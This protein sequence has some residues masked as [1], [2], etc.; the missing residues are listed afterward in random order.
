MANETI[1]MPDAGNTVVDGG[2]TEIQGEGKESLFLLEPALIELRSDDGSRFSIDTARELGSGGEAVVVIATDEDGAEYAAKITP[3]AV[4]TREQKNRRKVL[5]FLQE[6]SAGSSEDFRYQHL[7]PVYAHGTI[8]AVR[9]GGEIPEPFSVAIMPICRCLGD[10]VLE[11]AFVK[12]KVIPAISEAIHFLHENCIVHRDV[13]PSNIFEHRGEIVLGDF[14][15]S[16]VFEEG[17]QARGTVVDRRTPGYTP[18]NHV[19]Q[20]EDDWYSFGYTIW[21]MY[22]GNVHPHQAWIDSNNLYLIEQ[23]GERPVAFVPKDP[24]DKTLGE[25]IYGLTAMVWRDRLGYEGVRSWI[26]SPE[27]FH[28]VDKKAT[29]PRRPYR[30]E[31]EEL[32]D[33]ISIAQAFSQKWEEAKP[34]LYSRTLEEYFKKNGETDLAS[35]LYDIVEGDPSTAK[36]KDLGLAEAIYLVSGEERLMFWKGSDVSLSAL[37]VAFSEADVDRLFAYDDV[38][39]SPFLTWAMSQWDSEES[40]AYRSVFTEASSTAVRLP[41]F[42]RC[43][44][45]FAVAG[46]G[47]SEY[48]GFECTEDL[49]DYALETPKRFYDAAGSDKRVDEL[50]AA[51]VPYFASAGRLNSLVKLRESCSD[52]VIANANKLLTFFDS[53]DGGSVAARR[54]FT[55]FS[56][57]AAWFWMVE[58]VDLYRA[59]SGHD[60]AEAALAALGACAF[61]EDDTVA[62]GAVSGEKARSKAQAAIAF[63]SDSPLF[64]Q[65][66]VFGEHPVIA[67]KEDAL[68]CAEFYGRRVPR[69]FVRNLLTVSGCASDADWEGVELVGRAAASG[70]VDQLDEFISSCSKAFDAAQEAKAHAGSFAK[71]VFRCV[72]CLLAGAA[73]FAALPSMAEGYSGLV[74]QFAETFLGDK[75]VVAE[76]VRPLTIVTTSAMVAFF[77]VDAGYAL[78]A[79]SR[80]GKAATVQSRYE[81]KAKEMKKAAQTF[82]SGEHELARSL[83]TVESNQEI[84]SESVSAEATEAAEQVATLFNRDKDLPYKVAWQVTAFLAALFVF[85]VSAPLIASMVS[86]EDV[87]LMGGVPIL[88]VLWI[89]A[90]CGVAAFLSHRWCNVGTWMLL[91]IVPIVLVT[92]ALVVMFVVQMLVYLIAVIIGGIAVLAVFAG[93]LSS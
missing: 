14:G 81:G 54:F 53:V 45:Q 3:P 75:Q 41:R 23:R 74:Y 60:M 38:L 66:G 91:L 17:E 27:K 67:T 78:F 21:T 70:A 69:G 71:S 47:P 79:S 36:D 39:S 1:I 10:E 51:F 2:L 62:K 31:G 88:F 30:F 92:A 25:L 48:A 8:H 26:E 57:Y 50:F 87:D 80:S 15:I 24:A 6:Q 37:A 35:K 9:A 32:F 58:H 13:K 4:S 82:Q 28:Y 5:D 12:E 65:Y 86:A 61:D 7:M 52:D 63:M 83:R 16:T 33:D 85:A 76:L 42:A 44:V 56:L 34:H 77:F 84:H 64:S 46:G 19:V 40:D 55:R 43:I 72:A 59:E 22:N 18:Y 20:Y 11:V 29:P 89:A 49:I 68:V 93:L 73:L 90:H